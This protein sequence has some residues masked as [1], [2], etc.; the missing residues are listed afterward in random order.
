MPVDAS[1]VSVSTMFVTVPLVT[2]AVSVNANSLFASIDWLGP[3]LATSM[4][5]IGGVGSVCTGHKRQQQQ[6]QQQQQQ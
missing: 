3:F 6:Q 2:L 4:R 5:L 1:I